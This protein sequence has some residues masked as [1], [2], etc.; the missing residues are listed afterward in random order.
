MS[1]TSLEF[2]VLQLHRSFNTVLDVIDAAELSMEGWRITMR[3]GLVEYEVEH[4]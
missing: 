1:L 3:S 2:R 4:V